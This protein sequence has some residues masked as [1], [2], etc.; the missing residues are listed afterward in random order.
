MSE[1]SSREVL[2]RKCMRAGIALSLAA[3]VAA[4][5]WAQRGQ[6]RGG[7]A[8]PPMQMH[9]PQGRMNS[10]RMPMPRAPMTRPMR[11]PRPAP[12]PRMR[13]PSQPPVRSA[14]MPRVRPPVR[15][16]SPRSG[17][18]APAA[19]A[20]AQPRTAGA[21]RDGG[22]SPDGV[23][24]TSESARRPAYTP[25]ASGTFKERMARIRAM[26][27]SRH[28]QQ[29]PFY[30][31][32]QPY[33]P[34]LWGWG[35]FGWA[36]FGWGYG[37]SS[38]YFGS[39]LT[40][41]PFSLLTN[42]TPLCFSPAAYYYGFDPFPFNTGLGP[43]SYNSLYYGGPLSPLYYGGNCLL[44]TSYD[45]NSYT[46]GLSGSSLG[47][48]YMSPLQ[49]SSVTISNGSLPGLLPAPANSEPTL[50]TPGGVLPSYTYAT[51]ATTNQ[52]VTLVLTNGT[53]VEATQYRLG[54]DGSFH[55]VTVAGEPEAIPFAQL[56]MKATM[57][58]N[59]DKGVDFLVPKPQ[60]PKPQ[61]K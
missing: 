40:C 38:L 13:T 14:P 7:S 55:Y 4:P 19:R 22:P 54:A 52:P 53:K 57:K 48:P 60:Q 30:T 49:S 17:S 16:G 47:D 11:M 26:E 20:P 10:P 5:A 18:P 15:S 23:P 1:R 51:P 27:D 43:F 39:S 44:C 2:F 6:N 50:A 12:M 29:Q 24:F 59:Q 37:W 25:A 46:W 32:S 31:Y 34:G 58:A 3:V 21:G 42:W 56:D 28:Q 45:L 8:R 35:G 9:M 41:D 36:G 33:Y 61:V